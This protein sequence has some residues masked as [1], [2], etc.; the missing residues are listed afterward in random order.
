MARVQVMGSEIYGCRGREVPHT[1]DWM[2]GF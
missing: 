2:M 1:L